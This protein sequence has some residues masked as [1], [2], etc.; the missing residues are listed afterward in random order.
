M[1]NY[2]TFIWAIVSAEIMRET[3]IMIFQQR[4]MRKKEKLG[5]FPKKYGC[6]KISV[7]ASL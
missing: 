1:L 2:K 4:I 7:F 3:P 6:K 5:K